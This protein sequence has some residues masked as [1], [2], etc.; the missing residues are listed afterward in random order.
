MVVFAQASTHYEVD[1]VR[2]HVN[3]DL[4]DLEELMPQSFHNRL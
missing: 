3:E 1:R 4:K 2:N